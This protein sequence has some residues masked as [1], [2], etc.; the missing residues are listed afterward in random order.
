MI[1]G[2]GKAIIFPG[3][4]A[5]YPGMGKDLYDNF[6]RAREVF[7]R[8]DDLL[9]FKISQI[10]FEGS[11]EDLKGPRNQQLSLMAVCLSAYELFKEKNISIDLLSGLSLGEYM[12][13]YPAGVLDLAGMVKL[14]KARVMATQAAEAVCPSCLLAVIG[15]SRD[16]LNDLSREK[17]FYVANINT[18]KQIVIA[19]KCRDKQ[20]I[21]DF[22]ESEGARVVDLNV[23]GG[24]H[25]PL[26]DTARKEFS[27]QTE[28][29]VFGPA[30]IPIVSNI[31]ALAATDK[32][33][34]KSNLIEQLSL[35][36]LWQECIEVMVSEG[37]G[38]FFEIGP[39]RTLKG[40]IRK[41]DPKIKV[42]NI[43]KSKDLGKLA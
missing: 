37:V 2:E 28:K 18:P 26:M 19:L 7:S 23:Q 24:F 16:K 17:G 9:G 10:C 36:A 1:L 12:C 3:Q 39:S 29:L 35:P 31:S 32:D 40:M 13:L 15:F 6:P 33:E 5:Q 38:Q 34:I 8:I 25:S 42:V 20:R 11:E 4:G 14:I 22:L 41:I 21:K 30:A 27:R 43:E